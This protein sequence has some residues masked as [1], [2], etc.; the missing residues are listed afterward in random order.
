MLKSIHFLN[1]FAQYTFKKPL[2]KKFD[3]LPSF[4]IEENK[5]WHDQTIAGYIAPQQ[6]IVVRSELLKVLSFGLKNLVRN[7]I[8]KV[9][10]KVI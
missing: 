8:R 5:S 4:G 10:T 1:S 2:E 6:D 9:L 7:S 3:Y